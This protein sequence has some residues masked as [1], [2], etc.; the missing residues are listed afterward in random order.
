MNASKKLTSREQLNGIED[1]LVETILNAS[2]EEWHTEIMTTDI[3]ATKCI[4]EVGLAIEGARAASAKKALEVARAEVAAWHANNVR[5]DLIDRGTAR[6]IFEKM[7]SNDPTLES[8][9]MMAARKGEG[10]SEN[11][12]DGLLDDIAELDRLERKD[13]KE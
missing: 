2:S 11:D 9:M 1:A 10:L 12:F 13:S 5:A 6:E 8:K 3:D 4:S 7:R